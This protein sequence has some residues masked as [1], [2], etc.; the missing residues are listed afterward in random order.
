MACPLTAGATGSVE[1]AAKD[2]GQVAFRAEMQHDE[3]G[4]RQVGR[5]IPQQAPQGFQPPGRGA[6]HDDVVALW[7]AAETAFSHPLG[8]FGPAPFAGQPGGAPRR[9]G[10]R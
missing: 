10:P 3:N 9:V 7:P 8:L 6:D 1:D 4:G 2:V 5:Q